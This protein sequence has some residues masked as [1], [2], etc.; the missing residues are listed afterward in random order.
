MDQLDAFVRKNCVL[1][2][3]SALYRSAAMFYDSEYV[4]PRRAE[5]VRVPR[6]DWKS[7]RTHYTLH[8]CDP[9]LQRAAAVRAL[10]AVRSVQEMSLMRVGPDG[11]KTLDNK[12]VEVM[13]KVLAAQ[14]RQ[15]ALLD[16]ARM[17]PPGKR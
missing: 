4:K 15:M 17:P 1:V 12:Q 8:C 16:S 10:G 5:G 6:F 14:D 2:Q 3:E 7:M 13:L 9:V 11:S